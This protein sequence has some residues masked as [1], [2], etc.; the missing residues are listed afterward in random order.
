M[1]GLAVSK[2]ER[3]YIVSLV[4]TRNNDMTHFCSFFEKIESK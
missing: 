1:G 2:G 3:G 4:G